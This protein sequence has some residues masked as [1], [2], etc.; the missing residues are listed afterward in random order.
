MNFLVLGIIIIIMK[1]T[2]KQLRRI[3]LESLTDEQI[4]LYSF[5]PKKDIGLI[6]KFGLAGTRGL[7]ENRELLDQAFSDPE[8]KQAFIDR[9]DPSDITL[10]GPSVFFQ[11]VPMEYIVGLDGDHVLSRSEHVMMSINWSLFSQ[12]YPDAYIHGVEL[13][14]YDDDEYKDKKPEIEHE[15]DHDDIS[16]LSREPYHYTWSNYVPG[17]FAGNVPHGIVILKEGIIPP[18]YLSFKK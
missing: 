12:D 4:T 9:Y 5:V 11:H 1:I 16:R 7:I 18:E 15:L 2:R 17:Y 10:Q 3:I 8:E 13:I 6:K 14:P